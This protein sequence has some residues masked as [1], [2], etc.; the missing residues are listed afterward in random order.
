MKANRVI[1]GTSVATVAVYHSLVKMSYSPNTFKGE[2]FFAATPIIVGGLGI[3]MID[4]EKATNKQII[5]SGTLLISGIAYSL[6]RSYGN[7]R[8]RNAAMFGIVI[9]L[10]GSMAIAKLRNNN[11]VRAFLNLT[12]KKTALDYEH[13]IQYDESGKIKK[14]TS[15]SKK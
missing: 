4:I 3:S 6:L 13:E 14:I 12:D 8:P 11:R 9:G 15:T 7:L 5:T 2:K 10:A 1:I